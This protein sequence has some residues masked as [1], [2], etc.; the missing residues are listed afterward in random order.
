MGDTPYHPLQAFPQG[1]LDNLQS[2]HLVVWEV[3]VHLQR[4]L[5]VVQEAAEVQ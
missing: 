1:K 2:T 4:H 3:P 5:W